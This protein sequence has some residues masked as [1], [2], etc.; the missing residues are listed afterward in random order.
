[1]SRKTVT[2]TERDIA[3]YESSV[4]AMIC[5]ICRSGRL[6]PHPEAPRWRKCCICGFCVK[7][8]VG[9]AKNQSSGSGTNQ[10]G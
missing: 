8:E 6:E 1:M 7:Q 10:N 5:G 2:I 9:D 3:E 4:L